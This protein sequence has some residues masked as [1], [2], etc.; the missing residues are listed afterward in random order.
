MLNFKFFLIVFLIST[1]ISFA[2]CTSEYISTYKSPDHADI[3]NPIELTVTGLGVVFI[4]AFQAFGSGDDLNHHDPGTPETVRQQK[5]WLAGIIS[6]VTV[7]EAIK[8][9]HRINVK[10]G[11]SGSRKISN[12]LLAWSE[13]YLNFNSAFKYR[14]HRSE[15]LELKPDLNRNSVVDEAYTAIVNE[16]CHTTRS[17]EEIQKIIRENSANFSLC[18]GNGNGFKAEKFYGEVCSRLKQF[19]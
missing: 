11:G 13:G 6:A 18:K 16:A 3:I 1:K 7:G 14:Y 2:S 12:D 5:M 8:L 10:K 17:K 4:G 19:R 15:N 9:I